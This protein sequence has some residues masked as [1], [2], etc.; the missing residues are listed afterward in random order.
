MKKKETRTPRP[1]LQAGATLFFPSSPPLPTP[2]LR[3][4]YIKEKN[5]VFR[6]LLT[7]SRH[8]F[9]FAQYGCRNGTVFA[10]RSP[11]GSHQRRAPDEHCP[12][13]CPD[14]TPGIYDPATIIERLRKRTLVWR[15]AN[16]KRERDWEGKG[17]EEG[18]RK[19]SKHVQWL[20]YRSSGF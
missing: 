7:L 9:L 8:F 16:G 18:K 20:T 13:L 6:H 12:A 15:N 2:T 11:T 10:P 19:V 14:P 1:N 17:K 4:F 5:L 3:P